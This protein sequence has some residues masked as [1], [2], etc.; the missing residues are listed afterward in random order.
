MKK[1]NPYHVGMALQRRGVGHTT[2]MMMGAKNYDRPFSLVGHTMSFAAFLRQESN[3]IYA[4]PISIYEMDRLRGMLRPTIIDHTA[5]LQMVEQL[6]GDLAH[7]NEWGEKLQAE[8]TTLR[9]KLKDL[10]DE[11]KKGMV[12]RRK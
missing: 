8:N 1:I 3:N 12:R 9:K 10:E 7:V 4:I 6:R 11:A 5:I 2:L